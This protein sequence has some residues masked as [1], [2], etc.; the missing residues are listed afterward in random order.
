MKRVLKKL[1]VVADA[2]WNGYVC[3]SADV[4][5]MVFNIFHMEM[6]KKKM[7]CSRAP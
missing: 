4:A 2:Y 6:R 3:K 1:I 7:I 5:A